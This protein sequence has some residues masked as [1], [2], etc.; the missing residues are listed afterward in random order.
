MYSQM[1][2]FHIT[3]CVINW[4][5][6]CFVNIIKRPSELL[7]DTWPDW[8]LSHVSV[9]QFTWSH[10]YQ[11]LYWPVVKR[12]IQLPTSSRKTDTASDCHYVLVHSM[13]IS[14]I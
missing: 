5:E 1:H 8:R 11:P 10:F 4:A 12:P 2:I 13:A 6:Q 9:M 3:I 14:V 7:T